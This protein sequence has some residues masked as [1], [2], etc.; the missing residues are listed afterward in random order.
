MCP[1]ARLPYSININMCE[2]V[3]CACV[4]MTYERMCILCRLN[5]TCWFH[6]GCRNIQL[7]P[8]EQRMIR[9]VIA[10]VD[11]V[12]ATH[13]FYDRKFNYCLHRTQDHSLSLRCDR[14]AQHAGKDVMPTYRWTHFACDAI[15]SISW[16]WKLLQFNKLSGYEL[17]AVCDKFMQRT[18]NDYSI[19]I[20]L[21][22]YPQ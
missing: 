3:R 13:K 16:I 2:C 15:S 12:D 9:L 6:F 21:F 1:H 22:F 8:T 5:R 20:R 14:S 17:S 19:T 4:G 18:W 11:V 7:L 10:T